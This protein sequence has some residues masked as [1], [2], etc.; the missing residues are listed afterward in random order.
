M[1]KRVLT[2]RDYQTPKA[3]Q[4]APFGRHRE[5][6]YQGDIRFL[7]YLIALKAGDFDACEALRDAHSDDFELMTKFRTIEQMFLQQ[8]ALYL[9]EIQITRRERD[10]W[11][12]LADGRLKKIDGDRSGSSVWTLT[13][14]GEAMLKQTEKARKEHELVEIP[15][16]FEGVGK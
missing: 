2:M 6:G 9:R 8:T 7:D 5:K 3:K 12:S 13:Q 14:R 1:M 15:P 11:K 4:E 10:A 16:G